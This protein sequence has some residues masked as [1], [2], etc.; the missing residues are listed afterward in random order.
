MQLDAAGAVQTLDDPV[1]NAYA[2]RPNPFRAGTIIIT[3]TL[4]ADA[5][6]DERRAVLAHEQAHN[7]R[8]HALALQLCALATIL[9]PLPWGVQRACEYSAER[10]ADCHAAD[11]TSPA[12]AAKRDPPERPPPTPRARRP[13]PRPHPHRRPRPSAAPT[14]IYRRGPAIALTTAAIF[15]VLATLASAHQTELLFQA[16]RTH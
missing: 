8:R 9:D 11:V 15:A 16:L 13:R 3:T 12:I 10:D 5:G 6:P 2:C 14:T 7:A 1:P 4:L